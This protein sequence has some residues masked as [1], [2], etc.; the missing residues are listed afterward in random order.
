M[1]SSLLRVLPK[2]APRRVRV[3]EAVAPVSP[4]DRRV[5]WRATGLRGLLGFE[6]HTLLPLLLLLLAAQVR[7]AELRF[8]GVLGNSGGTGETLVTFSGRPAPRMGPVVE[9][10]NTIWERGGANQLN[11]CAAAGSLDLH[12]GFPLRSRP[13]RGIFRLVSGEL[14]RKEVGWRR[15]P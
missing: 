6:Q 14:P 7:S 8:A 10:A 1:K 5:G 3:A 13:S 11:R 9:A 4:E 12:A 2:P 15:A